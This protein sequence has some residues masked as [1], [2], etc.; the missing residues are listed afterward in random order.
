MQYTILIKI[1]VIMILKNSTIIA[2][3]FIYSPLYFICI[4]S[5]G[6]AE[7]IL[8]KQLE[9]IYSQILMVLTVKVG[10]I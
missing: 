8:R 5:T 2:Y 7:F 1:N 3:I 9:F 6:E 10:Y 4:S